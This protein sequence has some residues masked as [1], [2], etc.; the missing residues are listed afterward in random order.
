MD[1]F[2][3]TGFGI[4]GFLVLAAI[5]SLYSEARARR[6]KEAERERRAK[7]WERP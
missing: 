4:A 3:A 7:Q 6:A 1:D 5:V 2:L